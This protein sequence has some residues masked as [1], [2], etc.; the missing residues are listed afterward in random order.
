MNWCFLLSATV[1]FFSATGDDLPYVFNGK[2]LSQWKVPP[3]NIWWHVENGVLQV[4]SDPR[5][6]AQTL[7]TRKS[8]RN[9]LMA[10]EFK[11]GAGTVD[12]GIFIRHEREQ[13]Q[14]GN[15][16]SMNRDMTGSPYI[17]GRGYPVEAEGV[18]EVLRAGDWN[19][20][21]IVAIGRNY[22]VWLNDRHVLDFDSETS[23]VSGPIGIQL[24]AKRTMEVDYRNIQL[25]E[26]PS[27]D[28]P[29]G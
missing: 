5:Q 24:H 21:V 7:W 20:M 13:I 1:C 9:F 14:I 29:P 25:A 4:R 23:V 12:T 2:E 28:L 22:S 15:S 3:D 6:T 8:Y 11:M 18:K 10:F 19:R 26:I 16:G 27:S 17:A